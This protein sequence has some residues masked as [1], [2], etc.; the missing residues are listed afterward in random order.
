MVTEIHQG[1][2]ERIHTEGVP[3]PHGT[4][5]QNHEIIGIRNSSSRI[6]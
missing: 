1:D 2:D 6:N 4:Y 3:L 5:L